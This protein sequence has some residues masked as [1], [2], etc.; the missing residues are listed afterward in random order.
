MT[1]KY[2]Y[3]VFTL[4]L[5]CPTIVAMSKREIGQCRLAKPPLPEL[6]ALHQ[7]S[8]PA[9]PDHS[10]VPE[11]YTFLPNSLHI[12][13]LPDELKFCLHHLGHSRSFFGAQLRHYP[14]SF[15]AA[16]SLSGRVCCFPSVFCRYQ[17]THH[18]S[19]LLMVFS[20]LFHLSFLAHDYCLHLC[21]SSTV[22]NGWL[23]ANSLDLR[24]HCLLF[25]VLANLSLVI[26]SDFFAGD[27]CGVL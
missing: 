23:S 9:I 10:E 4:Y 6:P 21:A 8:T 16:P 26:I 2:N 27:L 18:L 25:Q 11:Q 12:L 14:C 7:P 17:S 19:E 20:C 22:L 15:P 24:V 5:R 1:F 13:M 3:T